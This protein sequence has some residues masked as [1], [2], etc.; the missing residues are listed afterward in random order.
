[1]MCSNRCANPV[2]PGFS[3]ADPTWYHVFTATTGTA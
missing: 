1:M 2:R 3:S